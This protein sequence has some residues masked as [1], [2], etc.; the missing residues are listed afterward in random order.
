MHLVFLNKEQSAD[1]VNL[2]LA[3]GSTEP[4]QTP[5]LETLRLKFETR[6]LREPA[7]HLRPLAAVL[8][9]LPRLRVIQ[10]ASAVTNT[11]L[12]D[13]LKAAL[14]DLRELDF[15][16]PE[17]SCVHEWL[18]SEMMQ[19]RIHIRNQYPALSIFGRSLIGLESID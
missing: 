6:Y 4:G 5:T 13:V 18:H 14:P 15:G 2:V 9:R 12:R 7:P 8:H 3:L 10:V 11:F 17:T 16:R 1:A 19:V